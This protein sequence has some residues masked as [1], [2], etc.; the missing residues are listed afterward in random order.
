MSTMDALQNE[1]KKPFHIFFRKASYF[2]SKLKQ[3]KMGLHM[4]DVFE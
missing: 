3:Y 1:R 2:R 4:H